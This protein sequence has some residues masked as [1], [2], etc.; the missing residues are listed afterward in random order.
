LSNETSSEIEPSYP[1]EAPARPFR[2]CLLRASLLLVFFL[3]GPLALIWLGMR[4]TGVR[5]CEQ[6]AAKIAELPRQLIISR[7]NPLPESTTEDA[8]TC[9]RTIGWLGTKR[10]EAYELFEDGMPL[11]RRA[12]W[13]AGEI[14]LASTADALDSSG[15]DAEKWT[16]FERQAREFVSQSGE[17]ILS[18][19]MRGARADH[20]QWLV[21]VEDV[22]TIEIDNLGAILAAGRIAL[23]LAQRQEADKSI[24][25]ILDVIVMARDLRQHP[26]RAAVEEGGKLE[27]RA[28]LQLE[29]LVRQLG[30]LST[31]E[32]QFLK[33]A[34]ALASL[35]ELRRT[36]RFVSDLQADLTTKNAHRD[37]GWNMPSFQFPVSF[38][39]MNPEMLTWQ[40]LRRDRLLTELRAL[41]L[42][43]LY[44][45]EAMEA[46]LLSDWQNDRFFAFFNLV[47]K[48]GFKD[49]LQSARLELLRSRV[50]FLA[51]AMIDRVNSGQWPRDLPKLRSLFGNS[52]APPALKIEQ[53]TAKIVSDADHWT[54][55]YPELEEEEDEEEWTE[56]ESE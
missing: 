37:W 6:V 17:E 24:E 38:L 4:Q 34:V 18:L 53:S 39:V 20:L 10:D 15:E 36:A 35:P 28:L 25:M 21:R 42:E 47:E 44:Q 32:G 11:E 7:R 29:A 22:L 5:R 40:W 1:V 12:Q 48:D 14:E 3:I 23:W 56:E 19:I 50:C 49:R 9:Y 2:S 27:K 8:A 13:T 45:H 51:A 16:D 46:Q 54:V 26:H 55:Q 43:T 52:S 41:E 31:Q 33:V 30:A